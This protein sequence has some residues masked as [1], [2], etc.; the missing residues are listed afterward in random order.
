MSSQ[1]IFHGDLLNKMQ[2]PGFSR[3]NPGSGFGPKTRVS[4]T[5]VR[6]LHSLVVKMIF[7]TL[8]EYTADRI[9]YRRFDGIS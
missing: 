6:V 2:N 5:R 1:V 7:F 8:L 3:K 9:V 4:G